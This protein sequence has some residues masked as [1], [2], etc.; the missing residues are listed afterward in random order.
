[1]S[2]SAVEIGDVKTSRYANITWRSRHEIVM[3]EIPQPL[4]AVKKPNA[5]FWKC[6]LSRESIRKQL[7]E[8]RIQ[9]DWLVCELGDVK[10]AVPI[11]RIDELYPQ[12]P[13]AGKDPSIANDN[14]ETDDNKLRIAARYGFLVG[15]PLLLISVP[16]FHLTLMVGSAMGMS[17]GKGSGALGLLAILGLLCALGGLIACISSAVSTIVLH[18]RK[19]G[20]QGQ[21]DTEKGS[22]RSPSDGKMRHLYAIKKPSAFLWKCDLTRESIDKQLTEGRI[23]N[24]WLVCE[25]GDS[26]TAVP[27]SRIDEL[28]PEKSGA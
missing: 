9:N 23:Q 4:Y 8:G 5:F 3:T 16:I 12:E 20:Q 6:N 14:Y 15:V 18:R 11:A 24:D 21:G 2:F 27:I 13:V 25:I 22:F 19:D 17:H 1:M 10:T 28:Y 26:K 7:A